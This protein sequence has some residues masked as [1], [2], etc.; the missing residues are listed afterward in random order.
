MKYNFLAPIMFSNLNTVLLTGFGKN[1]IFQ[2]EI[3]KFVNKAIQK[4]Y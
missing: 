2:R 4:E 1:F 3:R